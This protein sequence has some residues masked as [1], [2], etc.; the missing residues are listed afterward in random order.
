MSV[1]D[2]LATKGHE[3]VK[4]RT[5]DPIATA[6]QQMTE[7]RIGAV[8]VE[9]TK[10]HPAGIFTERDFL[11]AIGRDGAGIL[12]QPVETRMTT[13]LVTCRPADPID[14]VMAMM[15]RKRIRHMPVVEDGKLLGLVSI[16]D[17]VKHRLEEKVLEAEVL[18][19]IARMRA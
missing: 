8:V 3:V 19:E 15:T 14:Q 17:L 11:Y 12:H 2:I 10:M 6:I 13:P 7:H 4:I 5:T 1:A 18:K 9:D 16:G